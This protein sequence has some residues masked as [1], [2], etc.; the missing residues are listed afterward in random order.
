MV[1]SRFFKQPGRPEESGKP[2]ETSA[3][4]A[5]P[6]DN[7]DDGPDVDYSRA[8][9]E[10]DEASWRERAMAV[11]PT[12]SSTGSKRME[13]LWGA[14][15]AHAPSH[16]ISATGCRLITSQGREL[17][18]CTMGLGAVAIGY[19][20]ERVTGSAVA[21]LAAGNVSGL[22]HVLEV[23]VAERISSVVPCAEKVQFLKTGAEAVSAAIRIARTYTGRPRVI[24]CGYFGWHDWC[25]EA[26]GVPSAT[27]A[28]YEEVPFGDIPAIERAVDAAGPDLAAIVI[29]PVVEELAP[30]AWIARARE[31]ATKAGAALI[32]DEVKTGFRL[33]QGGFQELSGVTPDLATFGKALANGY[34]LSAVCG[35]A[36]LMD[37]LRDTW[38]SS[39]L[40]G[41]TGALAAAQAVLELHAERDVCTDLASIGASMRTAIEHAVRA[42]KRPGITLGGIDPMWFLRFEDPA[43]ETRFLVAAASEGLLLKRGAYNFAS[44]AHDERTIHEIE[45]RASTALVSL[46]D[47]T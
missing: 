26:R 25:S 22:P 28:L 20:D 38:V 16:Y 24:G 23:D 3:A 29:E 36:P 2:D 47:G 31:L 30:E 33:R 43:I 46:R 19:A 34:A 1:F 21:A 35:A 5:V 9:E 39:T 32:F 7:A 17:I 14:A 37:A 12:G 11:L 15:D 8:P 18:D 41:E 45:T 42:S 10:M 4:S 44:L 40:A 6:K 27:R 13:A